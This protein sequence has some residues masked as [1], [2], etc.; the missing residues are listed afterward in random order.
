M[1][2]QSQESG[3]SLCLSRE[4]VAEL[5][6][7]RLKRKQLDFLRKNGILHYLDDH[8]WPVVPRAAVEGKRHI[9]EPV[10]AWKSNKAA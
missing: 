6:R 4:E 1:I 2:N 9:A 3:M 7:S 10:K 5:T 8:D